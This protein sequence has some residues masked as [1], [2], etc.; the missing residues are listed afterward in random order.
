MVNPEYA[1]HLRE[2]AN[3]LPLCPGVYIMKDKGGKVIYV[4]KSRKLKNRVS[5]YFHESDFK[6][7]KTDAMTFFVADFEYILCD[8]EIEA[9]SLENSL[10]K[11]YRPRYN[12]R[13]K[14]D[15]SYPYLKATVNDPY[16]EFSMSRKRDADKARYFGPYTGVSTVYSLISAMQKTF[17]LPSCRHHFPR[18]KGKIKSCIYRQ[19]G[20][21]APCLATVGSEEYREVFM[22]AVAFLSGGHAKVISKLEEKMAKAS[23]SLAFEAAAKYRDRIAAIKKLCE[24]Q[25]VVEAP[26]VDR[27][28]IAWQASELI[29][30]ACIFYVRNGRLIDSE[31]FFFGSG[32]IVDSAAVTSF[33]YGIYKIRDYIPRDITLSSEISEDDL[34]LLSEWMREKAGFS[35]SIRVP[36]RGDARKLC[37]LAVQNAVQKS[38]EKLSESKK[39]DKTLERLATIAGL[40]VVP[41]RIEAFDISNYGSEHITA[42]MVVY[43]NGKMKK[44][45]YRVYNIRSTT[46]QNDYAAMRE[47]INRRLSHESEMPLPDLFLI[48]GGEQHVAVVKD[49]LRAFGASVPVLGMAKDEHHKTRALI[50]ERGEISIAMEQPLFVFIYGIQEE[51]HRFT[52]S[53]MSMKKRKTIKRSVLCDIDGIGPAKAKALLDHFG[54][55]AELKKA[56]KEEIAAVPGITAA[57]A[58]KT[59]KFLKGE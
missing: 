31:T 13:L 43:E 14:D 56:S 28:I 47:A 22:Q 58:E 36:Q 25:K 51:V 11:L 54:G 42:G 17:G 45:D 4:G 7:P 15:K 29:P 59:V 24:K 53:R 41:E 16:P 35:V 50:D 8:T 34:S 5:Q 37:D 6:S 23:E 32:E 18:D 46:E 44:S 1:E 57:L 9:L 40:E 12:I 3:G 19:M 52:V 10:I 26:N 38:K 30:S 55:L 48:D 20:C 2:K 33:I 27:D 49:E 39:S 21:V